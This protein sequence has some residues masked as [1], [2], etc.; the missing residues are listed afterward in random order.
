MEGINQI[1]TN[2]LVSL[3]EQE[4]I[5]CDTRDNSGCNG[6][7]MEY[8]FEFIKNNGGITTEDEY[9]YMAED[10]KCDKSKVGRANI[11]NSFFS[12]PILFPV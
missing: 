2:K 5:D 12:Y 1:K 7:L 11:N 9:P 8:A 6:G 10:G 3:S 4:L